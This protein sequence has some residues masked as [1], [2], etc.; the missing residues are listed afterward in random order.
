MVRADAGV[1]DED[2]RTHLV[3]CGPDRVDVAQVELDGV[4]AFRRP[5]ARQLV[6]NATTGAR[7]ESHLA[8]EVEGH[9]LHQDLG[10]KYIM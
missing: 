5:C 7:H 10:D 6:A 9:E 4:E 2:R 3:E 8:A 1:V